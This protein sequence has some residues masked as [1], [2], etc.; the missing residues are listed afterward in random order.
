M[1]NSRLALE[2][3]LLREAGNVR[4]LRSGKQILA[5]EEVVLA[6]VTFRYRIVFGSGYPYTAPRVYLLN[7]AL[8]TSSTIHRFADGSLCLFGSYEWHPRCTGVWLHQREN[9]PRRSVIS[10]ERV[11]GIEPASQPWKGRIIA[12]IRYPLRQQHFYSHYLLAGKAGTIPA[13]KP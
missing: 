6:G 5:E 7:P 4:F 10:L 1:D 11:A 2:V 8:P 3:A 9:R 13:H 12:T